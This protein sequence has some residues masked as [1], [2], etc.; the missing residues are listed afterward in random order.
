MFLCWALWTVRAG[1]YRV[2]FMESPNLIDQTKQRGLQESTLRHAHTDRAPRRSLA[3]QF[4]RAIRWN[5]RLM[6]ARELT[7]EL[8]SFGM[9]METLLFRGLVPFLDLGPECGLHPQGGCLVACSRTRGRRIYMREMYEGCPR[10]SAQDAI[11]L[12]R[13][14]EKGFEWACRS[15]HICIS[16]SDPHHKVPSSCGVDLS[17]YWKGGF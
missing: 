12:L 13:G 6:L 8:S 16:D 7:R 11:L 3:S 14:F 15:P 10:L 9:R 1:R 2:R 17:K 5:Y 4:R